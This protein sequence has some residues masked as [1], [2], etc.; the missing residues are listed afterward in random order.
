MGQCKK[1]VTPLLTHW[2]Y[3]FLA[4]TYWKSSTKPSLTL[5]QLSVYHPVNHRL[6]VMTPSDGTNKSPQAHGNRIRCSQIISLIQ[7]WLHSTTEHMGKNCHDNSGKMCEKVN[8]ICTVCLV[9]FWYSGE[10]I[11]MMSP[12]GIIFLITGPSWAVST[13]HWWIPL[14]KASDTEF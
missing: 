2:S 7:C 1:D 14:I 10:C 9:I 5:N 4:L 8:G 3:V 12:N 6:H 13:S 11:M